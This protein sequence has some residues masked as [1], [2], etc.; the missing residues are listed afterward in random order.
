M[1]GII[2][3]SI[4]G[5]PVGSA[6]KMIEWAN[7]QL[8]PVLALDTPSG[9]DLTVGH[10]HHPTVQAAATLT[11]ALPKSGLFTKEAKEV[12]GDLYLGN[13]GVPPEIVC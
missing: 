8:A 12:R 11:L 7:A 13:I 10:V 5:D 1:N 6:K 3:Y 9:L 2:G 4:K